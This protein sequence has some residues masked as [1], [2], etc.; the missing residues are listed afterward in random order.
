MKKVMLI[1][2]ICTLLDQI[3]KHLILAKLEVLQT[4]SII[5]GFFSLTYLQNTGAAFSLLTSKTIF[6]ILVSLIALFL[7]YQYLLKNKPN[8]KQA[9]IYGLLVGGILGNLIDRIFRGYVVDYLDFTIFNYNFPVF[10]LADMMI[11]ISIILIIIDTY[12]GDKNE[13]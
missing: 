1:S 2:V 7:I 6:L 11:V 9:I 12:K 10:N 3:V 5:K 4:I 8:D 13:I